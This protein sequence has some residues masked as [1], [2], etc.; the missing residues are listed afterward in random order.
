MRSNRW[1]NKMK[2][3]MDLARTIL[4]Q[5]EEQAQGHSRINL[6]IQGRSDDEIAYHIMLLNQAGFLDAV[7]VSSTAGMAWI[8]RQLT[9]GGHEF[10]DAIRNDT[11]WNK[12]KEEAK[13][14]GGAGPF[15]SIKRVAREFAG[16][17]VSC[18]S[19]NA[20]PWCGP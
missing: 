15:E 16:A 5:V 4:E 14:H 9:W 12:V 18:W 7:D 3:D 1:E 6:D 13:R 11:V 20:E 10:L 8:P 17:G 19:E 2:R